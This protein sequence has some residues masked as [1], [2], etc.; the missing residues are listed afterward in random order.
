[1]SNQENKAQTNNFKK[2]MR[3]GTIKTYGG[4]GASIFIEAA[5]NDGKISLHGCIGPLPSGNSLGGCGQIDMEFAHRNPADNDSRYEHPTKP[6]DIKFAKGW[7]AAKWFDLLDIWKQWHLNDMIPGCEHQTAEGWGKE[8][9]TFHKFQMTSETLHKQTEIERNAKT[10]LATNGTVTL[11]PEDQAVLNLPFS[12]EVA[13]EKLGELTEFLKNY[14]ETG[15]ETKT[16]GWVYEKDHP[17]GVLAKPCPVCGFKYGTAWRK[18]EI[19]KEVIEKLQS[20][21]DADKEPAWV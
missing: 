13:E 9:L 19:P 2:V 21:P 16:S 17:K 12:L 20:F 18:A 8:K 6:S 3:I 11:T 5:L 1:M 14:K 10:Q 7:N 15:T 4:R